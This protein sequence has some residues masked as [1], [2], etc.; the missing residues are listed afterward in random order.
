MDLRDRLI[1]QK[2][3]QNISTFFKN[4]KPS[5]MLDFQWNE[6]RIEAL[7]CDVN[8]SIIDFNL[9]FR[10][11]VLVSDQDKIIFVKHIIDNRTDLDAKY[12]I[13]SIPICTPDAARL[14]MYMLH[15]EALSALDN[16]Y[17]GRNYFVNNER[18]VDLTLA[19]AWSTSLTLTFHDLLLENYHLKGHQSHNHGTFPPD[20]LLEQFQSGVEKHN[21]RPIQRELVLSSITFV[22]TGDGT[23]RTWTSSVIGQ[24]LAKYTSGNIEYSEEIRFVTSCFA[25]DPVAGR[26]LLTLM[27]TGHM[28]FE[29]S[30]AYEGV[31]IF[32]D[33][34]F[35]ISV[36]LYFE[37]P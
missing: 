13:I 24:R 15:G 8:I 6:G 32:M 21:K 17:S 31:M 11:T 35:Q 1:P 34:I 4:M 23:G 12:R 14:Y 22:I 19:H 26:W 20:G 16:Y 10:P 18:G 9:H 37:C 33:D 7:A 28:L 29:I 30:L 25:Y 3:I 36:C 27:L 5:T 2:T